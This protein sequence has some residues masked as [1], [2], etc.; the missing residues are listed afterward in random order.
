VNRSA[1]VEGVTCGGQVIVSRS[2][3][4]EVK[5]HL[6]DLNDP[7]MRELGSVTLKGFFSYHE[8]ITKHI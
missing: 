7:V 5:D 8:K 3:W 2:T 6:G 1:R 4:D